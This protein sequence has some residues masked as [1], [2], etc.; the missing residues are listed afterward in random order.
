MSMQP[1]ED[2]MAELYETRDE[3]QD[4]GFWQY[5]GFLTSIAVLTGLVAGLCVAAVIAWIS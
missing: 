2:A 1:D 3:Y 4:I 5:V